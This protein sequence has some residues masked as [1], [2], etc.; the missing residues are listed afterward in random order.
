[1]QSLKLTFIL[2]I[3]TNCSTK[4]NKGNV[5]T[6]NEN[7][8]ELKAIAGQD[9]ISLTNNSKLTVELHNNTNK[10]FYFATDFDISSNL[11]PNGDFSSPIRK[12]AGFDLKFNPVSEWAGII[13]ENDI[14][15]FPKTFTLIKPKSALN[16]SLDIANHINAYNKEMDAD[17]NK[18]LPN[19]W[20]SLDLLFGQSGKWS[21]VDTFSGI[22]KA[23]PIKFYLKQ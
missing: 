14:L 12:L 17:S 10:P 8:F 20:Y 18:L 4:L 9:T 13:I 11:F 5:V 16:Y 22:I 1:M 23:D 19:R 6:N 15:S 3:L 7:N 21:S 2:L